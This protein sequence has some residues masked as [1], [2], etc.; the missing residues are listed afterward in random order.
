MYT[1]VYIHFFLF[2]LELPSI[3]SFIYY[4]NF[5]FQFILFK[6]I[7][8]RPCLHFLILKNTELKQ[9][10]LG[11]TEELF[12][13]NIKML[14]FIHKSYGLYT[15]STFKLEPILVNFLCMF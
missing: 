7:F 5:V 1:T 14:L 6:V 4:V 3:I 2:T 11:M 12:I 15:D 9:E 10:T 8:V 13:Y